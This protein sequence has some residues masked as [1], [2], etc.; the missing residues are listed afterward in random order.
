MKTEMHV[1]FK[2]CARPSVRL[3]VTVLHCVEAMLQKVD[4]ANVAAF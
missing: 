1:A 2:Q 3:D 4:E